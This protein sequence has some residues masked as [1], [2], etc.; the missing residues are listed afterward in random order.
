MH[1]LTMSL[2]HSDRLLPRIEN[3]DDDK[4]SNNDA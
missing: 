2:L 1:M 4:N 3:N